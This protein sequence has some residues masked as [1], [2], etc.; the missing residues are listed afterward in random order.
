MSEENVEIVQGFL[1]AYN[2]CDLKEAFAYLH[3]D[4]D[5]LGYEGR[6]ERGHESAV[7]GFMGWREQWESFTSNLD[8]FI[9]LGDNRAVL[10]VRNRG[11]GRRSGVEIDEQAGEIWGFRDGKIS[12]LELFNTPEDA[13]EAAGL[14]E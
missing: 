10:I 4:I 1:D 11:R 14:R 7:A 2:R 8:E 3:P 13:L 12:S 9:D 5:V 6:R